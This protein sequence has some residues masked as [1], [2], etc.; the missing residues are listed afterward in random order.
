MYFGCRI[1]HGSEGHGNDGEVEVHFEV[2]WDDRETL[3][4]VGLVKRVW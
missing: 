3:R 2:C 1:P 4:S